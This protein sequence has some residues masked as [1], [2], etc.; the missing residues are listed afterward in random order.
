[1]IA[2]GNIKLQSQ[3]YN[4]NCSSDNWLDKYVRQKLCSIRNL[5]LKRKVTETN[6]SVIMAADVETI[7]LTLECRVITAEEQQQEF[8]SYLGYQSETIIWDEYGSIDIIVTTNDL[9]IVFYLDTTQKSIQIPKVFYWR[10]L[11]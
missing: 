1:M 10:K 8:C 7:D 2:Q 6:S 4:K 5:F 9:E 3:K 11:L